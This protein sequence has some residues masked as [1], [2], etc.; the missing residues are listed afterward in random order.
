MKQND[1]IPYYKI[2]KNVSDFI[3]EEVKKSKQI[4]QEKYLEECKFKCYSL[5][6]FLEKSLD[7]INSDDMLELNNTKKLITIKNLILR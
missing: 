1:S 6:S 4:T 2:K 5:I 3:I 7:N